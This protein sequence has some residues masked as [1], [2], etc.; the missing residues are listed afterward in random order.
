MYRIVVGVDGSA[1]SERALRWA[2]EAARLRDGTVRV[3]HGWQQIVIGD[4][5]GYGALNPEVLEEAGRAVLDE[6]VERVDTEQLSAPVERVLVP[7][8][9][10]SVL[11]D[12]A[13]DADLV[14]V[15]TRGR[16]GF[17]GLLL[18]SVSH[19]VVQH[20]P[21]PAVVVPSAWDSRG[22][23]QI[24]VGVDGSDDARAALLWAMEWARRTEAGVEA[25]LAFDAGLAWIDVGSAYEDEWVAKATAKAEADLQQILDGVRSDTAEV[26]VH[27]VVVQ[28][29]AAQ[30]LLERAKTA[31][32]LVVGTRGRGGFAGLLLGSVS[33]R[34][35]EH[36]T[37]PVAVVPQPR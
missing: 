13:T 5:Y 10:A 12:A 26:T 15:G 31:D 19:Q 27:P 34:C 25:V 36:A 28:G 24:V 21:C 37:C 29:S 17:T 9:A 8:P 22:A 20:A 1:A 23:Q 7:G 30:V 2:V 18:G 14:V 33:Q 6:T 11:L 3:V 32:L 4:V 16:G 35:V